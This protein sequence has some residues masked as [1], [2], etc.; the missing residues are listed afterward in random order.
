MKTQISINIP[1]WI[2][3]GLLFVFLFIFIL[4]KINNK[5]K[6]ISKKMPEVSLPKDESSLNWIEKKD[7]LYWLIIICLG[8]I[9]IFTFKYREAS[10]VIDHWG[11]AGTIISII[12]AVLAII[13]TYYQS[14]TTV[15]ST[16]RLERS[17]KKVHKATTR[18]EEATKEL[19]SNNV[20]QIVLELEEKIKFIILEMKN[21]LNKEINSNFSSLSDL[22]F[23][24][25]EDTSNDNKLEL[26]GVDWKGYFD[27]NIIQKLSMEGLVFI[28]IYYIYRY[29]KHFSMDDTKK[30]MKNMGYLEEE[31]EA[32]SYIILGEMRTFRS[33]NIINYVAE[34]KDSIKIT[35]LDDSVK[36]EL[37][38]IFTSN[39]QNF[40]HV[41]QNL[42]KT[43][44]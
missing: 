33:L 19:E 22:I 20:K 14:A 35:K 28:Y 15:D 9:S 26:K 6:G 4:I 13:Y 21:E 25:T 39:Y 17:T 23:N 31:L 40:S 41:K 12:L 42:D 43:F 34:G 32:G 30:F 16:K 10:E 7:L 44:E 37:D 29:N 5:D 11:F 36:K 3:L 18:V 8:T 38:D 2:L 27:K 1:I 24:N